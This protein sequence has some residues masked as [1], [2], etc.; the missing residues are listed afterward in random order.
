LKLSNPAITFVSSMKQKRTS[1]SSYPGYPSRFRTG[2]VVYIV[3]ALTAE[4]VKEYLGEAGV[5]VE[6]YLERRQLQIMDS[7]AASLRGG[8][9]DPEAM[10]Q[11]LETLLSEPWL[12]GSPG[13]RRALSDFG[14]ALPGGHRRQ[15]MQGQPMR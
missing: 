5:E 8:F 12:K 4:R 3:D 1:G 14:G 13:E 7:E 10:I 6:P 11:L 9:F 2:K 15:A